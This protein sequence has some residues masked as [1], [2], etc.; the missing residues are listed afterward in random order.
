MIT[1]AGLLWMTIIVVNKSVYAK[2]YQTELDLL[3]QK[4]EASEINYSYL[5]KK[6]RKD[7]KDAEKEYIDYKE[8]MKPFED[9][10]KKIEED[11]EKAGEVTYLLEN[12]GPIDSIGLSD[13]DKV[14]KINNEYNKL[15]NEQK[16][17]VDKANIEKYNIKIKK[18]EEEEKD[19]LE[20]IERQKKL[21]EEKEKS[22]DFV[23]QSEYP[24][25]GEVME[26]VDK[27]NEHK[28]FL[29]MTAS[30]YESS[31]GYKNGIKLI[32]NDSGVTEAINETET[33]GTNIS[34]YNELMNAIATATSSF[35]SRIQFLIVN[36]KTNNTLTIIR[37]GRVIET[38]I[39]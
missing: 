3:S 8:K 5:E 30:F 6:T 35:D 29:G 33:M 37:D 31:D 20:E 36:P 12:I 4:Y 25:Y 32:S 14:T 34:S 13:K 10:A 24:T 2:H 27:L 21:E 7:I 9:E 26:F 15:T 19:R 16:K 1:I 17:Y 11:K 18:L 39:K 28:E 22:L 23:Y 38:L